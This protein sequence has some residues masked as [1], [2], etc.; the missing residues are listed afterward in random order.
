M[1]G[2]RTR[3]RTA[4]RSDSERSSS[5]HPQERALLTT[6]SIQC[7]VCSQSRSSATWK[8][9]RVQYERVWV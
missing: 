5:S 1:Y 7:A 9:G 2:D 6:Y 3:K 8:G 4:L